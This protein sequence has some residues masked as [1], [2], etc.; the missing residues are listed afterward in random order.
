MNFFFLR[1][2]SFPGNSPWIF[3]GGHSSLFWPGPGGHSPMTRRADWSAHFYPSDYMINSWIRSGP[4][5][6]KLIGDVQGLIGRDGHSS[7]IRAWPWELLATLLPGNDNKKEKPEP[8]YRQ[9]LWEMERPGLGG[10]GCCIGPCVDLSVTSLPLR[11]KH[12]F[13]SGPLGWASSH[14]EKALTDMQSK[15]P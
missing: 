14:T 11:R 8:K 13:L 5:W 10:S 3:L 9:A 12:P 15:L 2:Y 1:I 6:P 7:C 4:N